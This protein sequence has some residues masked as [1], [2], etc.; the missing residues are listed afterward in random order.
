MRLTGMFQ[1]AAVPALCA[2]AF[3]GLAVT[4]ALAADTWTIRPPLTYHSVNEAGAILPWYAEVECG[5]LRAGS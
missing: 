1:L 3:T 4:P 2:A 5:P